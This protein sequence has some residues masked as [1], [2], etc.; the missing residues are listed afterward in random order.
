MELY[1]EESSGDL[2][3]QP[4]EWCLLVKFITLKH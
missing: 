1:E 4:K 3:R 2:L